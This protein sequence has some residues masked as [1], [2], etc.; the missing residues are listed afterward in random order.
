MYTLPNLPY[1]YQDLEPYID[2]HTLGLHYNIHTVINMD[3]GKQI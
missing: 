1:N 3:C 2:T